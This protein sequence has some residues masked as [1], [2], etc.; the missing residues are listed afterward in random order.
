M[1]VFLQLYTQLYLGGGIPKVIEQLGN[2]FKNTTSYTGLFDTT[3]PSY[4]NVPNIV[5]IG[6]PYQSKFKL[7]AWYKRFR[8]LKEIKKDKG[9]TVTVSHTPWLHLL[10]TIV[11]GKDKKILLFHT[12]LTSSNAFT[13]WQRILIK[14]ILFLFSNQTYA[15]IAVSVELENELKRIPRIRNKV[16]HIFNYFELE[17][18]FQK[19]KEPLAFELDEI[20]NNYSVFV[21]AGRLHSQ[22]N[23]TFLIELFAKLKKEKKYYAAKLLIMGIG[24]ELEMLMEL[25][26]SEQLVA[27]QL[28]SAGMGDLKKADIIFA[29]YMANPYPVLRKGALYISTSLYEGFPIA[30]CEALVLQKLVIISDCPTGHVEIISGSITNGYNIGKNPF[31]ILLPLR[32]L[33]KKQAL[34]QWHTFMVENSDLIL[35]CN[36][37]QENHYRFSKEHKQQQIMKWQRMIEPAFVSIA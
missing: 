35:G 16:T 18:I 33:P 5:Q 11:G 25:A 3:T 26:H 14:A 30:V 9:V 20:L 10:N 32:N 36:G 23:F 1:S 6:S 4:L 17:E 31:G 7:L 22:K 28:K 27:V 29:G 8:S 2:D 15:C 34:H 13:L 21:T 12:S 19:S 24:P 37:N